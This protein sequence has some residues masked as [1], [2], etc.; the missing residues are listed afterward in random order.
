[1]P[2]LRL[3]TGHARACAHARTHT[4]THTPTPATKSKKNQSTFS[5][6]TFVPIGEITPWM[7]NELETEGEGQTDDGQPK[8]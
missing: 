3:Q 5:D 4:H 8:T 2:W 1:M 6:G 7:G